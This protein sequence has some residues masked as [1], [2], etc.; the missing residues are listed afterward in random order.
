MKVVINTCYGGFGLSYEAVMKYAEIKGMKLYG[1]IDDIHKKVWGEKATLNN[2]DI[3]CVHY[4]TKPIPKGR[5]PKDEFYWSERELER[6]DPA[7]IHVVEKMK[8]RADSRLSKLK[9]VEIPDGVEWEID[10]YDGWEH[11]AEKHRV[12]R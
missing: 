9:I 1:W 4:S 5:K 11:V 10:E 3:L 2:P 8:N 6:T 7:L 12:W